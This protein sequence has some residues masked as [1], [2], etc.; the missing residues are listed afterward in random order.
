MEPKG[1][2]TCSQEPSTGPYPEQNKNTAFK[3]IISK[4][5]FDDLFKI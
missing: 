1:S 2:L 5:K 3:K 4:E